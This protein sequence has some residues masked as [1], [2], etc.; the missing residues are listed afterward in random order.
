M[1]VSPFAGLAELMAGIPGAS[2]NRRRHPQSGASLCPGLPHDAPLG[3]GDDEWFLCPNGAQGDSPGQRP[4]FGASKRI[5]ALKGRNPSAR[6][7]T[8]R[9]FALCGLGRIDGL[10]P[11]GVDEPA[12]ASPERRFTMPW[13]T[14]WCPF[15]AVGRRMVLCPN[16]AQ[17][18]SPRATPWVRCVKKKFSKIGIFVSRS[19]G[20][21][22]CTVLRKN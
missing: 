19:R 18:D 22:Q 9:C 6:K 21:W 2:T 4:G 7:P 8:H 16:G 17:G 20:N 12:S 11:R 3:L 15:G 13:A 10:H 1:D 14:S 5:P